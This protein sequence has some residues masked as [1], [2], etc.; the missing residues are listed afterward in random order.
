MTA[1]LSAQTRSPEF[2]KQADLFEELDEDLL[3][4]YYK[5]RTIATQP[6]PFP[7][8]HDLAIMSLVLRA[9]AMAKPPKVRDAA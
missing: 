6:F 2:T 5:S 8:A 3:S 1:L 9:Q 7:A 4:M